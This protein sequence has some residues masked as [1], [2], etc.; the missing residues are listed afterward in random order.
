MP[1][2]SLGVPMRIN[3][4]SLAD[5]SLLKGIRL[6]GMLSFEIDKLISRL[7]LKFSFKDRGTILL[8]FENWDWDQVTKERKD[9]IA[10][11][12]GKFKV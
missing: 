3:C 12:G 9:L 11:N 1:F 8:T 5:F 4:L 2:P 6:N 7:S 10:S